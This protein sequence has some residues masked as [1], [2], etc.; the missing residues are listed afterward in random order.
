MDIY[1]QLPTDIGNKLFRYFRHPVAELI[2]FHY[3]PPEIR[4]LLDDISDY[5]YSLKKLYILKPPDHTTSEFGR[6]TTLNHLWIAGFLLTG[7]YYKIWERMFR[8][9]SERMTEYW[10][11]NIYACRSHKFQINTMWALF[12]PI[13]REDILKTV[14]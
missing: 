5:H 4:D 12:T 3:R 10:I 1:K 8:I 2:K 14:G 6:A 9:N 13:E 11:K 7:S